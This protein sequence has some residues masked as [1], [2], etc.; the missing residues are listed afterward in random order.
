[1]R[2]KQQVKRDF[3]RAGFLYVCRETRKKQMIISLL[4]QESFV[5][6]G[7]F[8]FHKQKFSSS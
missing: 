5:S 6:S 8:G 7:S 4:P 2:S 3:K 1:M